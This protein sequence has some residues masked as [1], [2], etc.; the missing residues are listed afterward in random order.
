MSDVS[1]ENYFF[2]GGFGIYPFCFLCVRDCSFV[3]KS[4]DFFYSSLDISSFDGFKFQKESK[5]FF[6]SFLRIGEQIFISYKEVWSLFCSI[7]KNNIMISFNNTCLSFYKLV[8]NFRPL[9]EFVCHLTT[10]ID[11]KEENKTR[12]N[13]VKWVSNTTKNFVSGSHNRNWEITW[14]MTFKKPNRIIIN[15]F[16]L[17]LVQLHISVKF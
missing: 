17:V 3:S 14:I 7:V 13:C 8:P 10:L 16:S 6:K 5:Y 12:W 4:N 1:V 15:L 2:S 9:W 11:C